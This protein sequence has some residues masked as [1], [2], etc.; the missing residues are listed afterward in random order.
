MDSRQQPPQELPELWTVVEAARRL[1]ISNMT[2]Y[3]LIRAWRLPAIRVG[4]SYRPRN[5]GKTKESLDRGNST[6]SS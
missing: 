5:R 6:Q 1:R 4:R 3:R 2:V